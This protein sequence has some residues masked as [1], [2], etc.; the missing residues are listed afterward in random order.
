M[1][2]FKELYPDDKRVPEADATIALLRVE[3]ARGA[4]ETGRF[5]ERYKRWQEL[6][7]EKKDELRER[8]KKLT[9]DEKKQL[10]KKHGG[11]KPKSD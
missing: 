8:W 6:P 4:F 3:Q 9:P 5:Y 7:P 10:R 1:R 11:R 2:D